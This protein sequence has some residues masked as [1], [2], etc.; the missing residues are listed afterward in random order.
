MAE[1]GTQRDSIK[2]ATAKADSARQTRI[3]TMQKDFAQAESKL[4]E[5]IA[6]RNDTIASLLQ[7]NEVFHGGLYPIATDPLFITKEQLTRANQE[8]IRLGYNR[9][10]EEDYL[11]SLPDQGYIIMRAFY[12]V[13]FSG[14]EFEQLNYRLMLMLCSKPASPS[15]TDADMEHATLDVSADLWDELRKQIALAPMKRKSA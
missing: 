5:Q 7:R 2:A 13:G 3:A 12:H 6:E 10:I 1:L 4:R 11:A 8:S 9:N 14:R 15:I